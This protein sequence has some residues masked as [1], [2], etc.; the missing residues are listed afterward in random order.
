MNQL[1]LITIALP[2]KNMAD[3]VGRTIESVLSQT[4]INW[5]LLILDDGSTD[6]LVAITDTFTDSRIRVI[7]DDKC[8]GFAVQL[9]LAIEL[10]TGKYFARID[11]DDVMYPD[12]LSR[13][14]DFLEQNPEVDLVGTA[15]MVVG[16]NG[17]VISQRIFPTNH[18]QIVSQPY[19]GFLVAHPTW[20]GKTTWFKRWYYQNLPRYEDQDLLLRAYQS[21]IYANLD[22]ILLEYYESHF[23]VKKRFIARKSA[24]VSQFRFFKKEQS[25]FHLIIALGLTVVKTIVDLLRFCKLLT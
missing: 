15:M 14:I 21:S 24:L 11:A 20:T 2:V 13:Q 16:K 9:N 3:T 19:N 5:K 7:S 6:N 12:R 8:V 25:Y 4:Y 23:Q 17:E 10:A 1:P 22:V 18:H